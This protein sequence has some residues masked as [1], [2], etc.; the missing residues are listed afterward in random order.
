[1][2]LS[3]LM[4]SIVTEQRWSSYQPTRCNTNNTDDDDDDDDDDDNNNNNNNT[5]ESVNVKEQKS[6]CRTT[7]NKTE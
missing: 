5:S 2:K 3:R 7:N 6:Q 1:M 4:N